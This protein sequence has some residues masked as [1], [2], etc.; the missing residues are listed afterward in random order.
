MKITEK[1][2]LNYIE[3]LSA[4]NQKAGT[5][6]RQYI[7]RHGTDNTDALITY[8]AALVN[9]YGEG[10]AELACQMYDAVAEASG[11]I[12]PTAEPAEIAGDSEIAKMVYG[13][14]KSSPLLESGVSR[15]VKQAGADTTLK[16]AL[17]DGAEWAWVPH[18][19][20][21]AFCITLASRGW[22]RASDKA[23]KGGHAQHIHANCDCEYAIRF[24]A[25]TT[26]AGYDPEKYLQQYED[27]GGD[28][29]A[30]RRANYAEHKDII[31]AKKRAAYAARKGSTT[32]VDNAKI[33]AIKDAMTKQVLALP[34]SAQ[35]ILQEYTGF[36]ATDVN[37]AIRN[38]TITPRIQKSVDA[39][40]N[41][42]ASGTM[43]QSVTLY[44]NTALSF[45]NFGLPS[46]PTEQELQS[47]IGLT[48]KFSIFTSTSFRDLHL[49]G[50]DTVIQ[51]HIPQG[52]AGCQ[53]LRPIALSK[54]K[55]QDEVLFARGMQYRVLNVRIE[56]DRYFLEIEVLSNV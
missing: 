29:N 6:M 36:M 19:D 49:P 30:M 9:K 5:Q 45:L 27:A 34:E 21:C 35:K 15:L 51:I 22:Q 56:N 31:N 10:C 44:R 43:P 42:L 3:R 38:G 50:R 41:A 7:E 48:P 13:T 12:V 14:K 26:V 4:I 18:G 11:V 25:N 53:Y 46:K 55:N 17:R 24:N 2:W 1:T 54:F 20:T 16:N 23:L 52:Y 37:R 28:I 32:E 33:K 39:L 8:A 47:L 40:D